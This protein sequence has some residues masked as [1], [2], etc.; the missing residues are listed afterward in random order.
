MSSNCYVCKQQRPCCGQAL[1]TL[2]TNRHMNK[3]AQ[4]EES[5]ELAK[6]WTRGPVWITCCGSYWGEYYDIECLRQS[7]IFL[8]DNMEQ[9]LVRVKHALSLADM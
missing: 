5:K 6:K 1:H 8:G 3:I 2:S 9:A 7:Y 4:V